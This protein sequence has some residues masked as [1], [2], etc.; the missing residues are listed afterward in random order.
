M[1]AAGRCCPG[2]RTL[3]AAPTGTAH[4]VQR[5]QVQ[6]KN[7]IFGSDSISGTILDVLR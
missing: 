4:Q 7:I 1:A 5:L 2:A 3:A 6:N